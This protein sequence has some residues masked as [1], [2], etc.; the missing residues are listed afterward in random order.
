MDKNHWQTIRQAVARARREARLRHRDI[1]QA[2]DISE[3]E[4]ISAHAGSFDAAE[5]PLRARRLRAEWP[6]IVAALE[7]LG[8][9]TACTRNVSCMHEKTGIYRNTSTDRDT[10][11]V[12]GMH[13]DLC[14][15]Y[16]HWAHGFAVDERLVDGSMQRSLQF[17][18]AQGLA[19]HK[20]LLRAASDVDAFYA[21]VARFGSPQLAA[22][23]EVA[24]GAAAPACR[25][26]DEVDVAAFRDAWASMRD[27][28]E[29]SP[30]L[31]RFGLG[32]LQALRLASPAFA[33]QV[34]PASA[35]EVLSRAAQD[36]VPLVVMAGNAGAVQAHTG[37]VKR[38]A[39]TGPCVHVRDDGFNLHLREDRIAAAWIVRKPT[40]EGLV[41][42]LELFDADGNAIAALQ[43]ERKPGGAE[44]CEWRHL[45]ATLSREPV[46]CAA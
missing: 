38:V 27:T 15:F 28:N 29:F 5:S 39:V 31:E 32:K 46:A 36:G 37:P 41:H 1:A 42:S 35:Q 11:Q 9:V 13:I 19:V 20:V 18:D 25:C 43:G 16:R 21:L 23:I 33:D 4:L 3:G 7:G 6:Q 30:L 10:G 44:R 2:L 22:G 17:F 34:E 45:L 8:E 40:S 26:D 12:L 14:L 24:R